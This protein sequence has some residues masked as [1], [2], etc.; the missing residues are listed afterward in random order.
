MKKLLLFT[1]LI[2]ATLILSGCSLFTD[3]DTDSIISK[4]ANP[5]SENCVDRGGTLEIREG[6]GGGQFGVCIFDD[7]S[8]CEEWA[9]F[10]GLC[11]PGEQEDVKDTDEVTSSD[12]LDFD[13]E[14]EEEEVVQERE[15][16]EE[17]RGDID[18]DLEVIESDNIIVDFPSPFTQLS[19]PFEVT[20]QARVFEN[21]V[22]VDVTTLDGTPLIQQFTTANAPDVGEFGN[23][24]QK[25]FYEFSSTKEGYVEVYSISA[26]DGSK[27]N[28]V[29]IPVK[30]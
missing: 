29:R 30:F 15:E 2:A 11:K 24:K 7:G 13:R 26:E 23:F 9:F 5:A 28:I 27:I 16:E 18:F 12:S 22:N 21:T 17:E 14:E 4:K 25:I 8:E 3:K 19:S 1:A 20:G 6:A 10:H